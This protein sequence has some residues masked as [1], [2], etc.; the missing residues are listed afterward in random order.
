MV[1]VSI[2]AVLAGLLIPA[3]GIL[4]KRA[5]TTTTQSTIGA[6]TV[7]ME[8][9][10]QLDPLWRYPLHEALFTPPTPPPAN[11]LGTEP[12]VPG[13]P[14][15]AVGLLLDLKLLALDRPLNAGRITDGWNGPILYQLQ[16]P[17]PAEGGARLVD[18][19]WDMEA[20]RPR[21]WDAAHNRPA[22]YPYIYSLGN[23][24]ATTDASTWIYHAR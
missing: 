20:V 5:R 10:R 14:E 11:I 12:V 17:V 15:G 21:S 16:R 7:A 23:E 9:Y 1:V 24:G 2:I 18:W 13:Y 3:V 22:P 6:L 8:T 19:N 4:R